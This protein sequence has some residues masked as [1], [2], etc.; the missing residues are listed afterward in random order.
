MELGKNAGAT[1]C[2][3]CFSAISYIWAANTTFSIH[4][5]R[6]YERSHYLALDQWLVEGGWAKTCDGESL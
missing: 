6:E 1:L 5:R 4:G 2:G 3:Y